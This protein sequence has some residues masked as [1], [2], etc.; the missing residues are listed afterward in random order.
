MAGNVDLTT[1]TVGTLTVPEWN[2]ISGTVTGTTVRAPVTVEEPCACEPE[3]LVDIADFVASNRD[4][5]ENA[6]IGLAYDELTGYAGDRVLELPC[7]R[8]S[9]GP[10]NGDGSLTLRVTARSPQGTLTGELINQCR[11]SV[12]RELARATGAYLRQ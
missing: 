6:L 10:V 8:Y 1:L 7:G 4:G 5:N 3:D 11:E 12:L 2:T 9:V